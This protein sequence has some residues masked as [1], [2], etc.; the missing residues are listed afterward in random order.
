MVVPAFLPTRAVVSLAVGLEQHVQHVCLL[1]YVAIISILVSHSFQLSVHQDV[2]MVLAIHQTPAHVTVAGLVPI[3]IQVRSMESIFFPRGIS[4]LVIGDIDDSLFFLVNTF[5]IWISAS[6][7]GCFDGKDLVNLVDGGQRAIEH[8]K[9]GDRIWSLSPD[10][11][12]LIPDEV[13]M[14]MHNGPDQP[15]HF[16]S[17]SRSFL[18]T[19]VPFQCSSTHSILLMVIMSVSQRHTT[20]LSFS[21]TLINASFCLHRKSHS[22]IVWSCT[23]DKCQSSTSQQRHASASIHHWPWLVTCLSTTFQPQ[24]FQLG[25]YLWDQIES[26]QDSLTFVWP[27]QSPSTSRNAPSYFYTIS[28][29][30]SCDAVVVWQ[31]LSSV[32]DKCKRWFTSGADILEEARHEDPGG[33]LCSPVSG[34]MADHCCIC[35]F[36][37][38]D[39]SKIISFEL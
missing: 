12:S 1:S 10:G 7:G 9:V 33:V 35:K 17:L 22:N 11:Q 36:N 6:G 34:S 24:S 38:Q 29:V 19:F 25:I 39:F 23:I 30:L 21:M 27:F 20:F 18:D 28:S 2:S 8:L 13:I 14:M 15:G 37:D 3:V 16:S 26:M 31:E 32:W 5:I 4:Y